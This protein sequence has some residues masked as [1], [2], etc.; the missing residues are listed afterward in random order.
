MFVF[1]FDIQI[2]PLNATFCCQEEV[3]TSFSGRVGVAKELGSR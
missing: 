1:K 2:R 3:Y